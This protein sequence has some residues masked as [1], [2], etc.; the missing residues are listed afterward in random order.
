MEGIVEEYLSY[1]VTTLVTLTHA[2][3]LTF[4]AVSVCNTNPVKCGKL[5]LFRDDLPTLWRESGCSPKV[6]SD[7]II[8]MN[9]SDFDYNGF[10]DTFSRYL[11]YIAL[12]S[13]TFL[14]MDQI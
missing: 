6:R 13:F 4:P 1:P 3:K 5:M 7:K 8:W 10:K 11:D 2:K 12:L 14:L 9:R